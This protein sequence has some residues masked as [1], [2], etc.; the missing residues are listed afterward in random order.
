[1]TFDVK[2][3]NNTDNTAPKRK[4]FRQLYGFCYLGAVMSEERWWPGMAHL[5][6]DTQK[7][8]VY[9]YKVKV[10]IR[11][12]IPYLLQIRCL[13]RADKAARIERHRIIRELL[14]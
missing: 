8:L 14:R 5:P 13:D 3:T 9:A 12:Q 4:Y 1:M 2:E 6:P 7:A 10:P 11:Q